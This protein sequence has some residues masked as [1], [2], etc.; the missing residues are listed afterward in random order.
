MHALYSR[1]LPAPALVATCARTHCGGVQSSIC[2]EGGA[3]LN[4]SQV[5][6]DVAGDAAFVGAAGFDGLK[7]D[8]CGPGKNLTA[9]VAALQA[10]GRDVL[11]EN[12]HYFK[13]ASAAD[14]PAGARPDPGRNRIWPYWKGNVTGGELVCDEH[15]FRT[16]G[17]I[18]NAWSSWFGN[19]AS[20]SYYQDAAHPISQ[21]GCWAYAD[22]LMVGV[23][24]SART[25]GVGKPLSVAEWRSHFGAW[26]VNSSPLIL[27]FDLANETVLD[28]VWP[29]VT[30]M[31][32]IA[33]NQAWSGHPGAVLPLDESG[34]VAVGSHNASAW[35][36]P[37][38]GGGVAV[39]LVNMREAGAIDVDLAVPSALSPAL[40]PTA[41][42][43]DVWA[44]ADAGAAV[45]GTFAVRGLEPHDSRFLVF[46]P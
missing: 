28:S 13:A 43:R 21:P 25:P 45:A 20:L 7:A 19:L 42:V 9:L 33:V 15:L 23:G 32:A 36:K 1:L 41:S 34:G 30:N 12:C 39:V 40:P 46:K 31:E 26:A 29:F 35:A 17:D 2:G 5:A 24:E 8:G 37:L 44:H 6:K 16:S 38:P 10:T 3:H 11:V 4:A 14:M 22:M 18:R 27:S